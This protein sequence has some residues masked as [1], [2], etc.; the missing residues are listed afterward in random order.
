LIQDADLEYDL[1]DYD[2]LIAPIRTGE[3]SF[4]LGSRHPAG[5]KRWKIRHFDRAAHLSY[6]M[7]AGHRCFS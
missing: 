5:Q 1:D 2:K 3:R 7:N 4:V 6:A